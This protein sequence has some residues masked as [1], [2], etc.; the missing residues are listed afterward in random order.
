MEPL[1]LEAVDGIAALARLGLTEEEREALRHQ[2]ADVLG[3]VSQ[4]A[5]LE[6]PEAP[7]TFGLDATPLR[8]D[9]PD[10]SLPREAALAN[11]AC[12][13]AGYFSVPAILE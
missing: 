4:L 1:T 2:L 13:V 10:A 12:T 9:E 11:A 6:L 7:P 3:Y 8:A 5:D